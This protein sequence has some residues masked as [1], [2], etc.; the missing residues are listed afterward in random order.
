ML[1]E[2]SATMYGP[3]RDPYDRL[4]RSVR[5]D[6]NDIGEIFIRSG[7]A[8]WVP[9]YADEYPELA[10]TYERAENHAHQEA[11]GFWA[12]CGWRRWLVADN[13][14]CLAT[15]GFT[16]VGPVRSAYSLDSSDPIYRKSFIRAAT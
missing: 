16:H 14:G 9:R 11:A 13:D 15:P 1:S 4:L 7:A 6:G 12:D 2:L 3:D 8:R 10:H 5:T